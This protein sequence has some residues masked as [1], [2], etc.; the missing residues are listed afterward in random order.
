MT[1]NQIDNRRQRAEER[2]HDAAQREVN[3]SNR[4]RE[5]IEDKKAKTAIADVALK[6][7]NS[8]LSGA[9]KAA[10]QAMFMNDPSWYALN[11]Q[12]V[13][14]T[15]SLSFHTPVGQQVQLPYLAQNLLADAEDPNTYATSIPGI[16]RL[17]FAFAVGPVSKADSLTSRQS[18]GSVA[19]RNLY[20]FVRHA[21]SGSS[22]Y[23]S[24]DLLLYIIAVAEAYSML[25]W[26]IRSYSLSFAAS[27]AN[28]YVNKTLLA[29]SGADPETWMGNPAQARATINLFIQKL[30]ALNV[31]A[32][33]PLF[34]RWLF[35]NGKVFQ[36]SPTKRSQLYVFS[37]AFYHYYDAANGTLVPADF[38]MN[39]SAAS[40]TTKATNQNVTLA[41]YI[42]DMNHIINALVTD[43]DI[44]IIS[45]DILKAYGDK[46]V[47]KIVSIPEDPNPEIGYSPEILA[48]INSATVAGG[49]GKFYIG[50]DDKGNIGVSADAPTSG[51]LTLNQYPLNVG[52][53]Y[54]GSNSAIYRYRG[55]ILNF[56]WDSPTPDDVMVASRFCVMEDSSNYDT[57]AGTEILGQPTVYSYASNANGYNT[58]Y[59]GGPIGVT[60]TTGA[61]LLASFAQCFAFDWA[62]RTVVYQVNNSKTV[63]L[64][65]VLDTM[66]YD[67]FV[68]L[69]KEDADTLRNMHD[70][71]V[72]SLFGI[73]LVGNV[74]RR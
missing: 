56:G 12:L 23:D 66:D 64:T 6:P 39:Y 62:P 34:K 16:M 68:V 47:F 46:G 11:P 73:P 31:P 14:D 26:G 59:W 24:T 49:L 25:Q 10:G 54:T 51:V 13:K 33:L 38:V 45:G 70:V 29:A 58:I 19:A 43:E 35:L 20:A 61:T 53:V 5:A 17:P 37:P 36:D 28:W 72:Q 42:S 4:V 15:A 18:V 27:A 65:V 74:A 2:Q 8:L 55:A 50:Q 52:Q 32:N 63:P 3:R 9:S 7:F 57:V 21:N 40:S 30:S 71:A 44:G 1:R 67:T 41:Q 60:S 22:N 69:T 48:Q